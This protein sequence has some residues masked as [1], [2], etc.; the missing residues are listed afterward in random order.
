[1]TYT[2]H[3]PIYDVYCIYIYTKLLR[4]TYDILLYMLHTT[5]YKVYYLLYDAIRSHTLLCLARVYKTSTH[6]HTYTK[7]NANTKINT[8]AKYQ[9]YCYIILY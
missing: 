7:T 3:I 1:M 5:V 9:Y 6:T 4:T 8:N 2:Y